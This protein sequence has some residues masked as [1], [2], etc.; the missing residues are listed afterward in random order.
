[1]TTDITNLTDNLCLEGNTMRS[2]LRDDYWFFKSNTDSTLS[3]QKIATKSH[4]NG[5]NG[6]VLPLIFIP[7]PRIVRTCLAHGIIT[8]FYFSRIDMGD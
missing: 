7:L 8:D 5:C 3:L 6:S 1:M 2:S 4:K